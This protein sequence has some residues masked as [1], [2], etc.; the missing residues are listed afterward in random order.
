[1]QRSAIVDHLMNYIAI[2]VLDG[3]SEELTGS[4]PLLEWGV[5]NSI[6]IMRLIHFIE[7]KFQV[8][9]PFEKIVPEH[10]QT[11]A[12]IANLVQQLL[13]AQSPNAAEPPAAI[14]PLG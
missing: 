11:V 14:T 4:T 13:E 10:L 8:K 3:M 7:A 1:M 5:I 2:E 6:E 9:V 12:A